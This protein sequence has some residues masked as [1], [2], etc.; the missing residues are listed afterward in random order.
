[1]E[2]C[3]NAYNQDHTSANSLD[4][5]NVRFADLERHLIRLNKFIRF[6][7]YKVNLLSHLP[8]KG[9]GTPSFGASVYPTA[10]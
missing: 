5:H 9:E 7:F 2:V 8:L 6:Y 3:G 10:A 1:M 4:F